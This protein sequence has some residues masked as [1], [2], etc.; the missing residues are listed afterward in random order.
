MD[1]DDKEQEG[2]VS[3]V[4]STVV[5]MAQA[6]LDAA[7]S[8]L[9]GAKDVALATGSAVGGAVTSVA[10]K[11][12]RV[13]R[14]PRKTAA[15]SRGKPKR[16]VKPAPTRKPAAK[17]STRKAAGKKRVAKMATRKPGKKTGS[18]RRGKARPGR[19]RRP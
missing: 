9:E 5:D 10:T 13:I 14:K 19:S 1:Q 2:I 4:T 18:T 3:T 6:G 12:A 11:A 16:S 8:G 17:K 7:K 15:G